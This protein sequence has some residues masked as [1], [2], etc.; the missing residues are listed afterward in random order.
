METSIVKLR[1]ASLEA[2]L[3][4]SMSQS[5]TMLQGLKLCNTS[6]LNTSSRRLAKPAAGSSNQSIKQSHK[7]R[8]IT[9]TTTNSSN[10]TRKRG[11]RCCPDVKWPLGILVYAEL[12]WPEGSW[13]LLHDWWPDHQGTDGSSPNLIQ[14]HNRPWHSIRSDKGAEENRAR[15]G[16]DGFR[17][18]TSIPYRGPGQHTASPT[19]RRTGVETGKPGASSITASQGNSL[20]TCPGCGEQFTNLFRLWGTV[21]LLVQV[22]TA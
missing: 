3:K 20:P 12:T 13:S 7:H 21:Y 5:N 9:T 10:L 22:I 16:I 1:R 15:H 11:W 6:D 4:C 8:P 2:Q 19:L 14:P 17:P 18:T